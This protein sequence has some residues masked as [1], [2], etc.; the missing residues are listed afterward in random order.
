MPKL[1]LLSS[2]L[3]CLAYHPNTSMEGQSIWVSIP[4][5][6]QFLSEGPLQ[7]SPILLRRRWLRARHTHSIPSLSTLLTVWTKHRDPLKRTWMCHALPEMMPEVSASH[8]STPPYSTQTIS[9][10]FPTFSI[11][12]SGP[13]MIKWFSSL[14][15]WR[16]TFLIS[17]PMTGSPRRA[18]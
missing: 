7:P 18:A 11:P 14:G 4:N 12:N 15:A 5:T 8:L 13:H 10:T 6:F 16:Y 1:S 2:A 3:L 17:L 9:A